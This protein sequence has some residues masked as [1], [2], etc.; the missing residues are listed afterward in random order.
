[1]TREQLKEYGM[2]V[3]QANGTELVKL[4]L[5]L[6]AIYIGEAEKSVSDENEFRNNIKKARAFIGHLITS[7]NMKYAISKE[8][9]NIYLYINNE[10]HKA[11][12]RKDIT[13]LPRIKGITETLSEAFAETLQAI[14]LCLKARPSGRTSSDNRLPTSVLTFPSSPRTSA[15]SWQRP[16]KR[17]PSDKEGIP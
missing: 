14:R 3:T 10:L 12:I 7:L 8:L 1:M 9:F 5:E 15:S 6:A 4:T 13:L 17:T 16:P 2:K 11:G